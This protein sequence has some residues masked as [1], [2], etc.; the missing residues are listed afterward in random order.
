MLLDHAHDEFNVCQPLWGDYVS[1][2]NAN[3][4]LVAAL[5]DAK[6]SFFLQPSTAAGPRLGAAAAPALGTRVTPKRAEL[7]LR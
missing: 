6:K 1:P 7:V 2:P 4:K 3:P 5:L